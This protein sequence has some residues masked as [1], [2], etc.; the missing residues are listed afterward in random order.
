MINNYVGCVQKNYIV[1]ISCVKSP[2][3][4]A[5]N[6]LL[7]ECKKNIYSPSIFNLNYLS[8]DVLPSLVERVAFH[9]LMLEAMNRSVS[10]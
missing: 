8:V 10:V 6:D 4:F 7:I 1:E 5:S 3:H 9:W 2:H